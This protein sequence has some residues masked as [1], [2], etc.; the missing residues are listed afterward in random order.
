MLT[1][2]GGS[3][4]SGNT[5][6]GIANMAMGGGIYNSGLVTLDGGSSVSDNTVVGQFGFGG[7]IFNADAGTL[8]IRGGSSVSGNTAVNVGGGGIYNVGSV[9]ITDSTISG[10][11]ANFG[12]GGGILSPGNGSVTLVRSTVGPGNTATVNGGGIYNGATLDLINSTVSGNTA[13]ASGGGVHNINVPDNTS[14]TT[15]TN[16]TVTNNSATAGAGGG[17][18]DATPLPAGA[19]DN[20]IHLTNTIVSGNPNG[21]DCVSFDGTFISHGN[22]LDGDNS[23]FL[24]AA[25]NDIPGGN[26]GLGPLADNGGLTQTHALMTGSDAIDAGNDAVCEGAD[27]PVDAIDQRGVIRPQDGDEDGAAQCDI[28]AFELE[29][30]VAALTVVKLCPF[31]EGDA[32]F[33]L[34]VTDEAGASVGFGPIACGDTMSLPGLAAGDYTLTE[35]LA[36][37]DAPN[38]DTGIACTEGLPPVEGTTATVTLASSGIVCVLINAFDDPADTVAPPLLPLLLFIDLTLDNQNHNVVEIDNTN[39]NTNANENANEN[40]NTNENDNVQDQANDQA[41]DNTNEQTNN[42]TSSP[43]VNIDWD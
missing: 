36:G 25:M 26:A 41:Q 6:A 37:P 38:F 23:C 15:L 43:S 12:S 32:A 18:V 35:T 34:N 28:G 40:S 14:V 27:P 8:T 3:S 13:G 21:G 4:V 24:S 16:V 33:V 1:L 30:P 17:L 39:A 2:D 10:N 5:T 9:L 42:I 20:T 7:G 29:P 31:G 19:P 22:N 11:T